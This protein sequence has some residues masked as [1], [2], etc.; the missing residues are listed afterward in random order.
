MF[1]AAQ[2]LHCHAPVPVPEAAYALFIDALVLTGGQQP[3]V[4][5]HVFGIIRV[6][7]ILFII[8]GIRLS[9]T[10][11]APAM[12]PK[13]ALT[14]RIR[15]RCCVDFNIRFFNEFHTARSLRGIIV[16]VA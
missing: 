3:L 13:H 5:R 7:V 4:P 15:L 16:D 11:A 1:R 8:F 12:Q 10:R 14:L 9:A 2:L 6:K